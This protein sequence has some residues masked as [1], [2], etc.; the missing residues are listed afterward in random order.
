MTMSESPVFV[1][2]PGA[3]HA[4]DTFDVVRDLMHKRGLA[5]EAISTPSVGAFP[6]DKG[7][8][9]DIE[10]THAVLKEMVEAGRQVVVVNHSY[11]GMV[12][13]GAVEGLG[14]S[15]RCKV[16]LPGGVIMVVW[17]AAFVTPKGK[18]KS[19]HEPA[20]YE[21][22]HDMPSMYLFCNKDGGIPL[23]GQEIFAQTLGNPVTYHVDASHSA[24]LSMPEKVIDGLE[25]ALKEG[26]Q[27]S[28]IAVN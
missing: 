14:Y 3:W 10:H 26:R 19:F 17:M 18:S 5:T 6:P 24:F 11:G 2:V 1:F 16:G 12:G 8:H 22:W 20:T 4:T 9:A 13:A 21:P 27:Q 15:Q 25:I 7:L 23:A 28:G